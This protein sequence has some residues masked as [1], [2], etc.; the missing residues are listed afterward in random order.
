L[1]TVLPVAAKTMKFACAIGTS[2]LMMLVN[3]DGHEDRRFP[4]DSWWYFVFG[5][6]GALCSVLLVLLPVPCLA[7]REAQRRAGASVIIS[8]HA[9]SLLAEC[10]C[11]V[12]RCKGSHLPNAG[13]QATV[14]RTLQ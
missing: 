7:R 12:R 1:M 13:A 6:T 4:R 2:M 8:V 5:C 10:Y 9:L 14:A 11:K 3:L